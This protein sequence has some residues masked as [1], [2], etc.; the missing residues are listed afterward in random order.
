V[1]IGSSSTLTGIT[2]VGVKAAG[3]GATVTPQ[4]M[5]MGVGP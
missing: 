5:L 1:A 4:L 3:G 2:A